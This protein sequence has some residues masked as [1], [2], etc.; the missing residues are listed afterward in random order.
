MRQL[1]FT[2]PVVVTTLDPDKAADPQ[3]V[4]ARERDVRF[5]AFMLVKTSIPQHKAGLAREL[6]AKALALALHFEKIA[7]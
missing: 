7:T 4:D 3:W 6:A 1:Q 2:V 5:I